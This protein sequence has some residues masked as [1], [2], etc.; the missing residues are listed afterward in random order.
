M[1]SKRKKLQIREDGTSLFDVNSETYPLLGSETYLLLGS[2]TYLLLGSE[3]YPL[4]SSD[5]YS[6]LSSKTR[7]RPWL[8]DRM[9]RPTSIR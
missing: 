4:L 5:I 6:L 1:G 8:A 3:T 9:S 2:K 7:L